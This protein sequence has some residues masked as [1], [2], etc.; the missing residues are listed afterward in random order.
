MVVKHIK[1]LDLFLQEFFAIVE[2]LVRKVGTESDRIIVSS[3]IFYALL[4]RNLYIKR[5][6]KLEIYKKLNLII[7]NANGF[8]SV[9]YDKETK[10]ATRKMIINLDTYKIL[11]AFYE[12]NIQD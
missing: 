11:K 2:Y 8:A 1:L 3:K 9:L 7:C 10:K 6:E 5:R 12:T 4:D